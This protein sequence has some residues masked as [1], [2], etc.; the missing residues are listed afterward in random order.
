MAGYD[1]ETSDRIA[2][3]AS[4]V[5]SDPYSTP[6]GRALAGSALAQTRPGSGDVN[7]AHTS[8][9]L[10]ELASAVLRSPRSTAT[11]RELAGSVLSQAAPGR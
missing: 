7:P 5:L 1:R 9:R 4:A 6:T 8:A 10:A 11:E 3:L 2:R